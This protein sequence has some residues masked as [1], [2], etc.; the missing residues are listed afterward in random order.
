LLSRPLHPAEHEGR[1]EIRVAV[2]H[3]THV[4]DAVDVTSL[5]PTE[6]RNVRHR[7]ELDEQEARFARERRAREHDTPSITI[8][9][10]CFYVG[11]RARHGAPDHR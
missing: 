4:S 1:E 8:A 3:D 5:L 7:R 9:V 11:Y 10:D 6:S 2:A